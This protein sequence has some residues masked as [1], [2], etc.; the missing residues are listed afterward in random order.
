M[1]TPQPPTPH[2]GPLLQ[3]EVKVTAHPRGKREL[4]SESNDK[5]FTTS[6]GYYGKILFFLL[7]RCLSTWRTRLGGRAPD[8]RR[9]TPCKQCFKRSSPAPTA[10]LSARR[11]RFGR[12]SG[13]GRCS[14]TQAHS[15]PLS[16][17]LLA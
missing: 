6:T 17:Q 4:K 1:H 8:W 16:F 3:V 2:C 15:F 10:P 12:S 9:A 14:A 11:K 7:N 13:L 5:A